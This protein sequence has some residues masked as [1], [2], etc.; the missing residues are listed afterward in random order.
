M[1]ENKGVTRL[2]TT[3]ST[4]GVSLRSIQCLLK[5]SSYFCMVILQAFHKTNTCTCAVRDAVAKGSLVESLENYHTKITA[6]FQCELNAHQLTP[7]VPY[8]VLYVGKTL[9][10][11]FLL[12]YLPKYTHLI[13]L[14]DM[15]VLTPH[16]PLATCFI[17]GKLNYLITS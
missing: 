4:I 16:F 9:Y 1:S 5:K 15:L 8:S 3:Y 12:F 14:I 17:S 6:H 7:I 13:V 2:I 10:G 11:F